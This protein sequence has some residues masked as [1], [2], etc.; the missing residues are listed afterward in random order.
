MIQQMSMRHVLFLTGRKGSG[1][2]TAADYLLRK[3][4]ANNP[5]KLAYADSLKDVAFDLMK[6]FYGANLPVSRADLDDP[7]KKDLVIP[8]YFFQDSPLVIRRVLQVVG[9]DILRHHLGSHIWIS[10]VCTKIQTSDGRSLR[11]HG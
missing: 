1:K 6:S 4:A 9:T 11:P 2:D 10:N 5:I 8:G 7:H 3:Y